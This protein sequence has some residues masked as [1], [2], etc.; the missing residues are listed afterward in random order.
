MLITVTD[1][2][3]WVGKLWLIALHHTSFRCVEQLVHG[4]RVI[5]IFADSEA[6][7]VEV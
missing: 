1:M 2:I 7:T 6:A 5:D 3:I 4:D